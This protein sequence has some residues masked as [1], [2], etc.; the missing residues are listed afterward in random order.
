MRSLGN[1][2]HFLPEPRRGLGRRRREVDRR[3][4]CTANQPSA[5]QS[6]LTGSCRTPRLSCGWCPIG[7]PMR[8]RPRVHMLAIACLVALPGGA[9]QSVQSSS[10]IGRLIEVEDSST[11]APCFQ[12]HSLRVT[13]GANSEVLALPVQQTFSPDRSKVVAVYS[14]P[15]GEGR[16][17]LAFAEGAALLRIMITYDT[18]YGCYVGDVA[19]SRSSVHR[20]GEVLCLDLAVHLGDTPASNERWRCRIAAPQW[21]FDETLTEAPARNFQS[22]SASTTLALETS[23]APQQQPSHQLHNR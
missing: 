1:E 17:V 7:K 12:H 21:R 8:Q 23:N 3:V 14:G 15:R 4:G 18:D 16:R 10:N 13:Y 22:P 2:A 19:V 6:S 5:P 20:H 11:E 9:C